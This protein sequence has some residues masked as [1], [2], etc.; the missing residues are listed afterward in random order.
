MA[1]PVKRVPSCQNNLLTMASFFYLAKGE[2][3]G[4]VTKFDSYGALMI[5]RSNHILIVEKGCLKKCALDN[6]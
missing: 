6:P 4:I 1:R 2:K 5:N 3:S